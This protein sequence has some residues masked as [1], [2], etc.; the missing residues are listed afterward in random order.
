MHEN[1]WWIEEQRIVAGGSQS[2]RL[3][4]Q[5]YFHS[6]REATHRIAELRKLPRYRNAILVTVSESPAQLRQPAVIRSA[7]AEFMSR[8]S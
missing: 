1:I 6:E 2:R 4:E 3:W 5:D 8:A 7:E